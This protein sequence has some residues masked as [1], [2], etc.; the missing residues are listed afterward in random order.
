MAIDDNCCLCHVAGVKYT[1]R[2][3]DEDVLHASFK[4]HVFEVCI[5]N[6]F[7]RKYSLLFI[8]KPLTTITKLDACY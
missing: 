3:R 7:I 5:K 1:S 2:L 8:I 6:S 4:N